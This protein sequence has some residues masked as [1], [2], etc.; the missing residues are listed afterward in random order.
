MKRRGFVVAKET[1]ETEANAI[2]KGK[3]VDRGDGART[4]LFVLLTC[5]FFVSIDEDEEEEG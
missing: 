4:S 3:R 1:K 5:F 2:N